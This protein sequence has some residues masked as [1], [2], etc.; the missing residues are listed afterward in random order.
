[1][2]AIF[3]PNRSETR[4]AT[5]AK[6]I[7][8]MLAGNW[9]TAACRIVSPYPAPCSGDAWSSCVVMRVFP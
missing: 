9:H 6:I 2:T 3:G 4:A 5:S 8:A 1:M 7:I